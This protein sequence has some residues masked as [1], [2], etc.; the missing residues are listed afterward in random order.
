MAVIDEHLEAFANEHL[1]KVGLITE[2]RGTVYDQSIAV[3]NLGLVRRMSN[4]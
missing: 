1:V 2:V 4:A 3:R